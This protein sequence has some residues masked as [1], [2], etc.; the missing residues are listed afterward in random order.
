MGTACITLLTDYGPAS[1]FVGV[2][3]AVALRLAPGVPVLDLAH[4]VPPCDVR[5]GALLLAHAL[6]HL[7]PGVHVAVVD[8][9][10]G[11]P[12]RRVAAVAGDH[13]FVGPDNGL[14]SFALAAAGGAERA[15]VL[16]DERYWLRRRSAT[17]DGR[18]VF[19]PVAAHLA[20]GTPLESLGSSIPPSSLVSLPEPV[21]RVEGRGALVEV[22]LADR[23]GNLQ[24]AGRA[25]HLEG[26]GVAEGDELL[27]ERVA[28]LGSEPARWRARR[29][30]T[31]GDA[32]P[33]ELGVLL[34]SD[35]R[36]ALAV[37]L[38]SART[39]LGISPGELLRLTPRA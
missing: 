35:A 28:A 33:G 13:A 39:A 19:V 29:V 26:I 9:G 16:D 37:S 25:E 3:H 10:V 1:S 36:L 31:F 22:L 38:G 5:S 15:V 21:A 12:R 11:T 2:C 30:R 4:D 24:T 14:L 17:F 7:P 34:D 27:V 18:D 23:F 32:K 8:P 20:S 6:P